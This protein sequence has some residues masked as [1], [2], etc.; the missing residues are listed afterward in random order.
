MTQRVQRIAAVLS[1]VSSL[2][3][4]QTTLPSAQQDEK[5][6]PFVSLP[7]AEFTT[8]KWSTKFQSLSP[9]S[10]LNAISQV[11]SL[12]KLD[13]REALLHLIGLL[14]REVPAA[15]LG[16]ILAIECL[17]PADERVIEA[18]IRA[19]AFP[20]QE[21]FQL[22]C[23]NKDGGYR[24]LATLAKETN[25]T[26]AITSPSSEW[27][28][29]AALMHNLEVLKLLIQ[30]GGDPFRKRNLW[31][32]GGCLG[33]TLK[34]V[35]AAEA[36]AYLEHG[37]LDYAEG[38]LGYLINNFSSDPRFPSREK[39]LKMAKSR[40]SEMNSENLRTRRDYEYF[41]KW[42]SKVEFKPRKEPG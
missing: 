22:I 6:S 20:I 8:Q 12:R 9:E 10:K 24:A 34:D 1:L 26:Y 36:A 18:F 25:I 14:D 7:I 33:S 23:W 2:L 40:Q 31:V 38:V 5:V 29:Y 30:L 3:T 17:K 35:D 11:Q 4:G 16:E 32:V 21:C 13:R 37:D 27:V 28:Q 15:K 19:G 42:L 41:L 39:L